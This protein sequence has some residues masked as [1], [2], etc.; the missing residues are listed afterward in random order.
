MQPPPEPEKKKPVEEE[1]VLPP[2]TLVAQQIGKRSGGEREKN[3][4]REDASEGGRS[5][6][7]L[8][9]V[10]IYLRPLYFFS[11]LPLAEP[12]VEDVPA[13]TPTAPSKPT[14]KQ[15]TRTNYSSLQLE[16]FKLLQWKSRC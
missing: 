15:E 12:T 7:F 5:S 3:R 6:T 16:L 9:H 13:T 8:P 11:N 2:P 10:K 14:P 4:E 1:E